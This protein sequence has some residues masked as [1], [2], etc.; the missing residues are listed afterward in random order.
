VPERIVS[1]I[2]PAPPGFNND[3]SW[4]S[5]TGGST[6]DAVTL[7][8]GLA[9]EVIAG[10]LHRDRAAR[11]VQFHARNA[12]ALGLD[13][14]LTA[15]TRRTWGVPLPAGGAE[16]AALRATQRATLD[17]LLDLAGDA[18]AMPDVRA[19][20]LDHVRQLDARL[21]AMATPAAT[22][23]AHVAL[24][25]HDIARFLRGED[26]PQLRPRFPVI[27]LPWP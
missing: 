11:L 21:A 6:F 12:N 8:G 7:A 25:R 2:P 17:V 1:M 23:R 22:E 10:L 3:L 9:T 5:G 4:I 16:R 26:N 24:A 19:H 14:V 27:V 13:A 18:R 15:I 20:A